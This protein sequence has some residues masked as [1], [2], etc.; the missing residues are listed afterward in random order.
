MERIYGP[1]LV[2]LHHPY[3]GKVDHKRFA[4]ARTIPKQTYMDV[5][6][7]VF[8]A[9][10]WTAAV[11]GL[12]AGIQYT[13]V[14]KVGQP[15]S[16][17]FFAA[18]N[19]IDD[20]EQINLT[21]NNLH[22]TR[23]E[24]DWFDILIYG[25]IHVLGDFTVSFE[26]CEFSKFGDVIADIGS[27]DWG[28]IADRGVALGMDIGLNWQV[29]YDTAMRALG[30]YTPPWPKECNPDDFTVDGTLNEKAFEKCLTMENDKLKEIEEYLSVIDYC[31]LKHAN[32]LLE[33][34]LLEE[35]LAKASI[36]NLNSVEK[37]DNKDDGADNNN[38]D[39][40]AKLR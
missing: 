6:G 18:S 14:T 34:E 31:I 3:T 30:W 21:I 25:P 8:D 17:C 7:V 1:N 36:P 10:A 12:T 39:F 11:Y 16:N 9:D 19:V 27:L 28:L 5:D 23:G 15:M 40:R 26:H 37:G 13:E 20:F 4:Q 32:D 22:S 29:Y 24:F 33:A 2:G 35:E 38:Q